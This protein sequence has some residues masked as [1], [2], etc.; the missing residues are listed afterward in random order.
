MAMPWEL[1]KPIQQPA[2]MPWDTDKPVDQVAAQPVMRPQA[3]GG[4]LNMLDTPSAMPNSVLDRS[5]TNQDFTADTS[6][7]FVDPATL[8]V[9]AQTPERAAQGLEELK[10]DIHL[11]QDPEGR[12][13]MYKLQQIA[14]APTDILGAPQDIT[15]MLGNASLWGLDKLA[16]GAGYMTGTDLGVD[17]RIPMDLP[18]S[19]D[20]LNAKRNEGV[21]A[22][23][24][25]LARLTG[26]EPLREGESLTI[27]PEDVSPQD[28]IIG[29]GLR[30][31]TGGA[32]GGAL[33]AGTNTALAAPYAVN[34]SKALM[35]DVLAGG[36][37]GVVQEAYQEY[38]PEPVK[39]A[40]G[41]VGD[42]IAALV[43]GIGGS[44]V[45]SAGHA[46]ADATANAAK[47]SKTL[48]PLFTDKS[49]PIN[50]DTGL[51]TKPSEMDM[52]ARIMQN[53]PSDIDKTVANLK[54]MPQDFSFAPPEARPTT[55]MVANDIGMALNENAA[56]TKNPQRFL[57]RDA[58][59]ND[60][61]SKKIDQSVPAGADPLDMTAEATRQYEET[62]NAARQKVEDAKLKQS[63]A[64]VDITQQN[65]DLTEARN[66]QNQSSAAIDAELR[67]TYE[68]EQA[69]KNELYAAKPDDT[70]VD[71]RPIYEEMMAIEESVP[72]AAR[73]G[74]DYSAASKRIRD[75]VQPDETGQFTP[76]TYGDLKI[77]K[78]DVGAM[79]KEAVAAGRDVSQLDKVNK[80]LSDK[81][82][83]INPE[84]AENY[85]EN[86]APRFKTGKMGEFTSA[87]KRA[88]K[89]GEES[90]ATRPS[91]TA[92]KFLGKPEDAKALQR[93][94]D[95][96]GKPLT[97]TNATE[98]MMGD[99]AKSNVLTENADLRYDKFKQWADKNKDVID[100]FP[101]MRTRVDLELDRAARGGKL[102]KNLAND[103]KAAESG[104]KTTED[105]L[106]RS[107]L[108]HAIGADPVNTISSIMKSKNPAK[109][110]Q[111]LAIRLSPNKR[112]REGLKATVRDWIKNEAETT[113]HIVG[114][115][116][117]RKMSRAALDTLFKK[118]EKTLAAVYDPGEM[119]SL[120]QAHKLLDVAANLENKATAGSNTL[121]KFY[122]ADKATVAGRYRMLEVALKA[123]YGVLAGGGKFRTLRLFFDALGS[124]N[125]KPKAV[126]N[127]LM[128]AHFNAELAEH[129][130]TRNVKEIGTPAWN[131]KLN[132][133]LA[134]A[135]GA[136]DDKLEGED[137]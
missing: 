91:E 109:N 43:G 72:R 34:S 70:P 6:S 105:E 102:S 87:M 76:L 97:A 26:V 4:L 134:V 106:R 94:I 124:M 121:D 32:L 52:A 130:L 64:N 116:G 65:A 38:M 59:R 14:K 29:A 107:A 21:D 24:N 1:D 28:R 17:Y 69:K 42:I 117:G 104:L 125:T 27:P 132:R 103:V 33:A 68:A 66:R 60:L 86:F 44:T 46:V 98:W 30:F 88:A 85:S 119:N 122:A 120:R 112:A 2:A 82:N 13:Q 75:L 127:A 35:G 12:S 89:T 67:K 111:D 93:A 77:L 90:S 80:L 18:G 37:G 39:E 31:G 11:A 45:N 58:A 73:V 126:E 95:V 136:R 47:D 100:Q 55:G 131:G 99:L 56:R 16:Q 108:Q 57:E 8:N 118:H 84:A 81:I 123:K 23:A 78:T 101:A 92:G 137:E 83:A 7:L 62:L 113:A 135:S 96:N 61:A 128:E 63:T 40:L 53:M 114:T 110:L 133:L 49:T 19:S 54:A 79:R 5:P 3:T 48:S 50:P 9:P 10:R 20:W 36:G 115:E 51:M 129:L 74:T 22:A 25:L 15:A 71:A 41:P